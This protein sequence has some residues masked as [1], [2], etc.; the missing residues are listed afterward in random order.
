VKG[1]FGE[2]PIQTPRDRA[3]AFEPTLVRKGQTRFT[4]FDDQILSLYARGMSTRDI[5]SMFQEMYGAEISHTLI[6][7]VTE[8][9]VDGLTGFPDAIAAAYP[10]T[11]IKLCVVHMVR[12]SLRYVAS[13]HMKEVATDLKTIYQAATVDAAERALE[14]FA[15]KWDR[16]SASIAKSWRNHWPNLITLFDY[17]PEIRKVIYTTNVINI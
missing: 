5:A 9:V 15:Q 14:F 12:N 13:K 10:N 16:K 17:P 8:A 11:K 2:I 3:G 7:K 4:A 1:N 6:S